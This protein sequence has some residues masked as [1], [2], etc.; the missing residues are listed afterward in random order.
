MILVV[1]S[2]HKQHMNLVGTPSTKAAFEKE[3]AGYET[4]KGSIK[5]PY[6]KQLP[7][8]LIKAFVLYRANEYRKNGVKWM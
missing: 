6:D 2:G 8:E 1:M 3:L 5:L 4:G 7:T